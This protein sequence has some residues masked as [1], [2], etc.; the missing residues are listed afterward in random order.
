MNKYWRI[1][2]SLWLCHKK[3]LLC[4]TLTPS[5]ISDNVIIH[6]FVHF[7]VH[8]VWWQKLKKYVNSFLSSSCVNYTYSWWMQMLLNSACK[9]YLSFD[10]FTDSLDSI[11]PQ[12]IYCILRTHKIKFKI[13]R[14]QS[15]ITILTKDRKLY[16][17]FT[18][19][20]KIYQHWYKC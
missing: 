9:W 20:R 10:G 11:P 16:W 14:I 13:S 4:K 17:G 8:Y 2:L 5:H 7:G 15:K 19:R 18:L 3:I 6:S 1:F 12:I